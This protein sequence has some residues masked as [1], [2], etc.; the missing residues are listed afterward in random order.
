[1]L[2]SDA[3]EK[4]EYSRLALMA[5]SAEQQGSS[6]GL[7]R[8]STN[9]D[10]DYS[11]GDGDDE[12]CAVK[13]GAGDHDGGGEVAGSG[14]DDERVDD[15]DDGGFDDGEV[16]GDDTLIAGNSP[17]PL[18]LIPSFGYDKEA[19]STHV[20]RSH[21]ASTCDSSLCSIITRFSMG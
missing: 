6:H 11:E 14:V 2:S 1:M 20:F 13:E 19:R 16:D 15:G 10:V 9:I 21:L 3:D 5:S 18:S 12:D 7:N 4:D 8:V 17:Q